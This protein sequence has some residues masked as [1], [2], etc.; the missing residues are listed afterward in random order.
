MLGGCAVPV[1]A[2]SSNPVSDLIDL[3]PWAKSVAGDA[4]AQELKRGSRRSL[5]GFLSWMSRRRSVPRWRQAGRRSA[6]AIAA[7]PTDVAAHAAE[8]NA[9]LDDIRAAAQYMIIEFD[10]EIF[11]WDARD[12]ARGTS[13]PCRPS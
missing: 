8:L 11:R 7:D 6:T 9:I 3:I 13:P 12:D 2:A 10:G 1:P 5:R 4:S